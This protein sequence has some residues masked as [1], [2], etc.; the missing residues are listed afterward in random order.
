[1]HAIAAV[2]GVLQLPPQCVA[3]VD[4]AIVDVRLQCL[5]NTTPIAQRQRSETAKQKRK[6]KEGGKKS[7]K[8]NKEAHLQKQTK[9]HKET[10]HG[11]AHTRTRTDTYTQTQAHT[12]TKH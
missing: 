3:D 11:L 6:K 1:M 2:G 10:L 9:A 12:H 5:V 8:Q 7:T 4:E